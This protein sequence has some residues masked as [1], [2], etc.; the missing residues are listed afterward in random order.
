M[1]G[2]FDKIAERRFPGEANMGM[3]VGLYKQKPE[4]EEPEE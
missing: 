3:I 4:I 1:D 2:H